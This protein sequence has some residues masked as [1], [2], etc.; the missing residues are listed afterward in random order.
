VVKRKKRTKGTKEGRVGGLCEEGGTNQSKEDGHH[1][2][3]APEFRSLEKSD[4]V[5]GFM[6][7]RKV[8]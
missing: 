1:G 4:V 8:A 7:K 5:R 6:C 2:H 3:A